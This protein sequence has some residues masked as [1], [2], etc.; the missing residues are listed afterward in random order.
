MSEDYA[1]FTFSV[2]GLDY[3]SSIEDELG[4]RVFVDYSFFLKE[5]REGDRRG[6][7]I[8]GDGEGEPGGVGDASRIFFEVVRLVT[9]CYEFAVMTLYGH[10]IA[11]PVV[12][13]RGEERQG[14]VMILERVSYGVEDF[15]PVTAEIVSKSESHEGL[16]L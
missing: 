13:A 14:K 1:V 8:E 15:R 10:E 16:V 7:R 12:V 2:D 6:L 5:S 4:G 11:G 9:E 3:I